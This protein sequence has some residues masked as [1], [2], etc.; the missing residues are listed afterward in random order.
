[1][2][3]LLPVIGPETVSMMTRDGV[4][5]DAD[6]YRPSGEGPYPV[7]FQRQ[8]YGRRIACTICYAHPLWYAAR[9]YI[10][11][12]QDIRGR[13][14][15]EG[16]FRV[17]EH[18]VADGA[19]SVEWAARLP[20]TNG[21]VGMYGFSYQG[22]TQ[23][24]AALGDSPSLKALAP[25]MF[26]WRV[27][28]WAYESNAFRL[29][30]ALGWAIQIAAESARHKGDVKAYSELYAASKAV[31]FLAEIACR[32]PLI[33]KHRDLSHYHRWI[34]TLSD[35]PYWTDVSPGLH[36]EAIAARKLPVLAIGGWYDSQ[37]T[38]TLAAVRDLQRLTPELLQ[39]VIGPWAH[40]PWD[41]K[42]GPMDFG[43]EAASAM[44]ELHIRWFDHWLKD[45]PAEFDD[46]M[47]LFDMGTKTWR[48]FDSFP[49][50]TRSFFL[51]GD[52][53]VSIDQTAGRL[54]ETPATS[55]CDVFVHDPWRPAPATGGLFGAPP[56]PYDRS[57][58][59]QRGDV[60]TFTTSLLEQSIT[61]AGEVSAVVHATSD[62][63]SFDLHCVLSRV[64]QNGQVIP[65]TE[66][67]RTIDDGAAEIGVSMKATCCTIGPGE[68]LRLSIAGACFPAF[69]VN[70][71]TGEN[72]T[73]TPN[74]KALITT[75]GILYGS[76]KPS[77]LVVT[78]PPA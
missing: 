4:R 71:G 23:F 77:R 5:L 68:A 16:F 34:D 67:Y 72:A 1:M 41:R 26:P 21:K 14:T 48:S 51:S 61:I 62:V 13:G 69:P 64:L 12:V 46:R 32:P 7:L 39:T 66:G 59:D 35:D 28:D 37:L 17:G 60:L 54:L 43:P 10:V 36:L 52:G 65:L 29:G 25:A 55:G 63:K 30:G 3:D 70:P 20:G 45:K 40:F 22:Y 49:T 2:Q 6:V 15:S 57:S 75:T 11:V 33:E 78:T 38:G 53:K 8:A 31:P 44:D 42:V 76:N 73:T 19:E 24:M 27:R 58:T 50:T 56:G 47:R 18:D 74:V 9:G